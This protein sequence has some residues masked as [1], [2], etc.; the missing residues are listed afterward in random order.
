M[1]MLAPAG[2]NV[3]RPYGTYEYFIRTSLLCVIISTWKGILINVNFFNF[4]IIWL[5][6]DLENRYSAKSK[7]INHRCGMSD[8]FGGIVYEA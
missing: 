3:Y 2:R 4:A 5:L 7:N 8:K 6:Y 1:K